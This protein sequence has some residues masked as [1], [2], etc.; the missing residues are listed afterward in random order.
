[1]DEDS[2]QAAVSNPI[3]IGCIKQIARL[4]KVFY[5]LLQDKVPNPILHTTHGDMFT[6]FVDFKIYVTESLCAIN[7]R[8]D[9]YD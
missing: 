4:G 1:M 5:S 8:V 3:D 9:K 7:Q 6:D 2:F